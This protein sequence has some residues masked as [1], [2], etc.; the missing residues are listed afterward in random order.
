MYLKPLFTC[1]NAFFYFLKWARLLFPPNPKNDDFVP[2]HFKKSKD[3]IIQ[4]NKGYKYVFL[5]I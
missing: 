5:S 4:L 2:L 3:A 1:M